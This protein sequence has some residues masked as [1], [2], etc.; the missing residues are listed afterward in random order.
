MKTSVMRAR[1]DSEEIARL[2]K[3]VNEAVMVQTVSS[4]PGWQ[5]E[6]GRLV[7]SA[8]EEGIVFIGVGH[9]LRGDD[10]VGSYVLK[11]LINRLDA[12]PRRVSLYDAEEG[13]ESIIA[14]VIEANPKHVVFIDSC[15]MNVQ[16]GE[17][18]LIAMS[19]TDYPFFTTHGIPLKFLSE[20]LLPRSEAWVV[21][22]QPKQAEF[23][24]RMSHEVCE[25]GNHVSEFILNALAGGR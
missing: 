10:C 3:P 17:I 2:S 13:V 18:R 16:P 12:K 21:A 24:E 8:S 4:T 20:R 15:E 7:Q 1:E 11:R 14:K 23:G 5:A 19:E 22:V 6:L 9:P 25:A